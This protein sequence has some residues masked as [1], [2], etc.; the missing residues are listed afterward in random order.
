MMNKIYTTL[1]LAILLFTREASAQTA[2]PVFATPVAATPAVSSTPVS[3]TVSATAAQEASTNV[4][5]APA[6]T[7]SATAASAAKAPQAAPS[8]AT[9]T[10]TSQTAAQTTSTVTNTTTTGTPT[11]PA[12][13]VS[14]KAPA[15]VDPGTAAKA[16]ASAPPPTA[17]P[18]AVSSQ[19]VLSS[20][21]AEKQTAPVTTKTLTNAD[22]LQINV[23]NLSN[24]LEEAITKLETASLKIQ[25]R[26]KTGSVPQFTSAQEALKLAK[27]DVSAIATVA[28]PK[29]KPLSALPL[30]ETAVAKAKTSIRTAQTALIE[31][32]KAVNSIK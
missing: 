15:A 20:L 24:K 11:T 17:Q 5:S 7:G 4:T 12:G 10:A 21:S 3:P 31:A 27:S 22:Q 2:P 30:L 28:I 8:T 18:K 23:V 9:V 19:D 32:L 14:A 13:V 29:D 26:I 1:F 16:G 25:S 6:T